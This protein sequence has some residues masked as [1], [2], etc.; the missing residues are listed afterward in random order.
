ME[1]TAIEDGG[2]PLA[3]VKSDVSYPRVDERE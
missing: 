3:V 1:L 2:L